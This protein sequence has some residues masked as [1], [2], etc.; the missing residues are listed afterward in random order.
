MQNFRKW[1]K[2]SR[3]TKVSV[4]DIKDYAQKFKCHEVNKW[5]G[6]HAAYLKVKWEAWN[7]TG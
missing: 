1:G 4:L 7:E 3:L 6:R 2:Y 5:G